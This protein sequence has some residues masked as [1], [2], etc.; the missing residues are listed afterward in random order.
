M[1][2]M[3]ESCNF[4]LLDHGTSLSIPPFTAVPGLFHQPKQYFKTKVASNEHNISNM[5]RKIGY[6]Y[7]SE[8][9]D[10]AQHLQKRRKVSSGKSKEWTRP[11]LV[12]SHKNSA[13]AEECLKLRDSIV[14]PF[15][16]VINKALSKSVQ[17]N[18]NYF[19]RSI[20]LKYHSLFNKYSS[21]KSNNAILL[22]SDNKSYIL[23]PFS[24]FL[25][26]DLLHVNSLL[27][28]APPSKYQFIVMDPPWSNKSIKRSKHYRTLSAQSAARNGEVKYNQ[29]RKYEEIGYMFDKIN[30]PELL[31]KDGMLALW[32]TNNRAHV[33]H[34]LNVVFPKWG[35]DLVKVCFWLKVTNE[36]DPIV[37]FN[38]PHKKPYELLFICINSQNCVSRTYNTKE[39]DDMLMFPFHQLQFP[40]NTSHTLE[41]PLESDNDTKQQILPDNIKVDK[42]IISSIPCTQHSRKP[43]LG[44][45]HQKLRVPNPDT[46]FSENTD[47]LLGD[48]RFLEL[49]ARSLNPGWVSWG[50][51]V[52]LFQDTEYFVSHDPMVDNN[53]LNS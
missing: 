4:I 35:L 45:L 52:L 33:D 29:H 21:N 24:S 44:H 28:F 25:M 34:T 10:H 26:S 22:K 9:E 11:G 20:T 43:P 18:D 51:E 17:D 37:P 41:D 47:P 46:S 27:T 5:L 31:S 1:A 16:V 50:N 39:I 32:I 36:G 30:I 38:S 23:P 49:F 7:P 42:L 15:E 2:V 12:P 48:N 3:F 14:L 19:S 13:F 6:P 8:A 40:E 53:T